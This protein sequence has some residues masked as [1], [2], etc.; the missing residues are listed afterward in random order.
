MMISK[1]MTVLTHYNS[2]LAKWIPYS[3]MNWQLLT[4]DIVHNKVN[5]LIA[6]THEVIKD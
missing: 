5:K 6:N 4:S 2:C 3:N 1:T